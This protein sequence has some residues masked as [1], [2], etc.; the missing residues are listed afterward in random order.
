[1]GR[2]YELVNNPSHSYASNVINDYKKITKEGFVSARALSNHDIGR[3]S[4]NHPPMDHGETD[5][6]YFT[7]KKKLILSNAIN[8]VTPG[9]TFI[10]YG[11]ELGLQG[12]CPNGWNDMS[13][14]TPMP[15]DDKYLTKSKE[16]YKNYKGGCD[17]TT[18]SK[19]EGNDSLKLSSYIANSDSIYKNLSN[20][21]K[22]KLNNEF[23]RNASLTATKDSSIF[24]DGI[25]GFSLTN[26]DYKIHFLFN[27]NSSSKSVSATNVLASSVNNNNGSFSLGQY[28]YLLYY[29]R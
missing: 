5:G 3:F 14:R 2:T 17:G 1:M 22:A 18:T 27:G 8:A 10:Y 19:I 24:K 16:Y 7:E 6:K 12:S 29:E 28:D 9:A 15:W 13:Y 21:L 23:L 26:N 25:S 11:D 20:V 4:Q